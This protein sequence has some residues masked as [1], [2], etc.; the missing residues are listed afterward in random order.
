MQELDLPLTGI[1]FEID[2]STLDYSD[3]DLVCGILF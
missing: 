3:D 2:D 1:R